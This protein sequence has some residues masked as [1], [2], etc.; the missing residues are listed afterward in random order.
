ME[1]AY[2][3]I[4]RNPNVLVEVVR[5]KNQSA[6]HV[7]VEDVRLILVKVPHAVVEGKHGALEFR[8]LSLCLTSILPRYPPKVA[9]LSAQR[10]HY[11]TDIAM[12]KTATL[13]E[14][15]IPC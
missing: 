12:E 9:P 15:H 7:P 14:S 11:S 10:K 3:K 4:V 8:Y 5:S 6:L 2:T 1:H 13:K